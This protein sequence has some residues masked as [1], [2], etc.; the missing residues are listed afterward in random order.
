MAALLGDT[1]ST[2]Q[3]GRTALQQVGA[4][5]SHNCPADQTSLICQP[6][7]RR[8]R[9]FPQ[10]F[11][12][13]WAGGKVVHAVCA[14]HM[15]RLEPGTHRERARSSGSASPRSGL[16]LPAT[17]GSVR[18]A[19]YQRIADRRPHSQRSGRTP[20]TPLMRCWRA[21]SG[22]HLPRM[23]LARSCDRGGPLVGPPVGPLRHSG[24]TDPQNTF[25]KAPNL[26]PP[27]AK[28][29]SWTHFLSSLAW[30]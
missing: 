9:S 30:Q 21:T 25:T 3:H 4:R 29:A 2:F 26:L 14:S 12:A 7:A 24:N 15:K 28:R 27:T 1:P 22:S 19:S 6:G 23:P 8:R 20:G 18:G 13:R 5:R 16:D 11:S 17:R 10:T